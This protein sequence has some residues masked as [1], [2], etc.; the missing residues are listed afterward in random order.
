[1]PPDAPKAIIVR[2]EEQL[3]EETS[4]EREK[5]RQERIEISK[6]CKNKYSDFLKAL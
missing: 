3:P 5:K 6:K 2:E 4:A 1:M